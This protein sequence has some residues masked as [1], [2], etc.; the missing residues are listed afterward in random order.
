MAVDLPG[1]LRLALDRELEGASRTNLAERAARTSAAYRSGQGSAG[2]IRDADDALAYALTRLPATYAAC[3]T[4][5]DE[6]ARLA[7]DFQPATLLDAGTG[8][9]AASWAA[10]ETWM[11]ITDATWLDASQPFLTMAARLATDG[12]AVLQSSQILRRSLDGSDLPAADL[13]TASYVLAEI[14]PVAQSAVV[15]SLWAASAKMLVLIEPGTPAGTARLLAARDVL[16]ASGGD[17]LAPC[18]HHA[19]CPLAGD[20]LSE[21]GWCHFAVRLPRSRDHRLVKGADAPFEDEKFAYLIAARPGVGVRSGPRI[22]TP[23]RVAKPGIDLCLCEPDG[24]ARTLFV[25]R[26]DKPAYAIARRLGW[27]DVWEPKP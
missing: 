16:I 15:Q 18:P 7:P 23:P 11:G 10:T 8:T 27:G 21:P 26:R 13:V 19:A 20:G 9:A 2:V 4:V 6:A 1:P 14:A 5:F 3:V 22:L 25:P 12:P 24:D 17:I